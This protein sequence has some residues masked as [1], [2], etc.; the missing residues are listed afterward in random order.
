MPSHAK[1]SAIKIA[2]I[3]EIT[4]FTAFSSRNFFTF[5]NLVWVF[6][7]SGGLAVFS[8][9]VLLGVSVGEAW[10]ELFL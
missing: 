8:A 9:W 4:I 7:F 10:L 6:R 3:T 5:S 1:A 2:L